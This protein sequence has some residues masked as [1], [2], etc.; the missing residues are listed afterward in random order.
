M[1]RNYELGPALA[2]LS[3]K[4]VEKVK[5]RLRRQCILRFV[6]EIE[7]LAAEPTLEECHVTLPV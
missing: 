4:Q 6:E 1:G 7:A 5:L 3:F 2:A